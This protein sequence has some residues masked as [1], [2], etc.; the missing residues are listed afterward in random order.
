MNVI[1]LLWTVLS[2]AACAELAT[3]AR[4]S[5]QAPPTIRVGVAPADTYAEAYF[6][7][8]M[9]FF[10][11]A[12]MN[13]EVMTL[14]NVGSIASAVASG[15]VDVGIGSPIAIAEAHERGLPFTVIGPGGLFTAS[16]PTNVLMV[17]KDSSLRTAR[18]LDGKTVAD[19]NLRSVTQVAMALWLRRGGGDIATIR[20][21]EMPFSVMG[22]AL[23]AGRVDAATIAEPALTSARSVARELASPYETIGKRFYISCWFTSRSWLAKNPE[24]AHRFVAVIERTARWANRHHRESAPI[25]AKYTKIPAQVAQRMTRAEFGERLDLGLIQPLLD[26]A[27]STHVIGAPLAAGELVAEGF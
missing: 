16:A 12:G 8:E 25:L 26:A 7:Q 17:A 9:G 14:A 15:A 21:V 5:A 20:Y 11:A 6:A 27:T 3:G 2:I 1:R 10:R 13:V 19:D 18:D 4:A 24:L 22:P 23:A